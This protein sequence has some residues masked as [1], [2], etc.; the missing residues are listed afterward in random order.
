M[1]LGFID[2]III[3]QINFIFSYIVFYVILS[4]FAYKGKMNKIFD[5]MDKVASLFKKSGG[6]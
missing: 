6:K 2:Y 3:F 4:K 1:A 5:K